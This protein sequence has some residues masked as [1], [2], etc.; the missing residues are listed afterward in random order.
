MKVVVTGCGGFL[1]SAIV[2]LLV[3]RGDTVVG[4]GRGVYPLLDSLGIQTIRGDVRDV[5][6]VR[7][8]SQSVDAVIHT[9]AIA[10]LWGSWKSFYEINTV[11][12]ENVIAVC[13]ELG[14]GRLVH[15]SSPSVTFDGGHQR[16]IDETAP[17]AVRH[18]CHYSHTK[19]LAEIAV[20][21]ANQPGR[22]QTIA[23]RPHLI[24]GPG[25]PHLLPRLI[26]RSRRGRL[27][28]VGDG[29]NRIDTVHVDSAALAHVLALDKTG[30]ANSPAAGRAYFITQDQ[31]VNCWQ[32]I[33]TLLQPAGCDP[34][35]RRI[36][37]KTAWRIGATM[38][39]IYAAARLNH[40]PP[41]T[42]FLAAQLAR[43][44]YFDISAA[45]NLLGYRPKPTESLQTSGP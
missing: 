25:D 40:E 2:R 10:G 17:Y 15:C 3:A 6:A 14:I 38:E 34:P 24:W 13:Q 31:P 33:A 44:H 19:A 20:L 7:A 1:G 9:A 22:L 23:L 41:M 27:V 32:W 37:F 35:H 45:K 4:L 26:D 12:T 16:G 11:G 30:Q 39:R 8:A 43:D 18:L 36:G 28:I 29:R 42:R 5:A 21:A